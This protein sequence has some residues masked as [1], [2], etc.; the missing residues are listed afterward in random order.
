MAEAVFFGV[1][2]LFVVFV[3]GACVYAIWKQR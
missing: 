2:F 3:M 1:L